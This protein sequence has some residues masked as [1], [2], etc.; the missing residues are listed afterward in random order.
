MKK[1]IFI[2]ALFICNLVYAG[3]HTSNFTLYK[4]DEGEIGWADTVNDNFDLIDNF[5]TSFDT[6]IIYID[7]ITIDDTIISSS[8]GTVSFD[9]E[10]ILTDGYISADTAHLSSMKI[11]DDQS[12]A[13]AAAG[14][15]YADTNVGMTVKLGI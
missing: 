13:G 6:G 11:G 5:G 4:P 9:D 12:A 14:E 1:L 7:S 3:S 8:T 10:I 2:L 15:L